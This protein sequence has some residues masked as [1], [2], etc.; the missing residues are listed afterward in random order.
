T[1]WYEPSAPTSVRLP[2]R[3]ASPL[4]QLPLILAGLAV[5]AWFILGRTLRARDAAP[6]VPP[7]RPA[8]KGEAK[9]DVVRVARDPRTGW[10]GRVVDAHDGDP[11][12]EA[13]MTIQRA[14]F[15]SKETI[16]SCVTSEDGRFA[17]QLPMDA[18]PNDELCVEAPLHAELRKP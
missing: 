11:I 17:L 2:I 18:R 4:R 8:S 5:A 6:A 13:R 15:T 16:A 12:A 9:I 14:G 10:S 7:A 1:P 3:G